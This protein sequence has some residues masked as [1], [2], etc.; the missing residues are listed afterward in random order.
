[1]GPEVS[2]VAV[3][4]VNEALLARR[5]ESDVRSRW[6]WRKPLIKRQDL[7]DA[8]AGVAFQWRLC[9]KISQSVRAGRAVGESEVRVSYAA[10]GAGRT[11]ID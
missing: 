11:R 7:L 4:L 3:G 9:A 2:D 1:M 6:F 10:V 8:L 5:V